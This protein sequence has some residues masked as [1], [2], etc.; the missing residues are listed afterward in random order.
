MVN[1]GRTDK[2]LRIVV[3]II[4]LGLSFIALGGFSTTLGIIAILVAIVLVVTA[5]VNF[6]PAYRLLGIGTIKK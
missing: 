6:C 2:I 5:V 1:V 4:L 3:G